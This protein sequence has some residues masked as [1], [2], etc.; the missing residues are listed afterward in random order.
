[1]TINTL[2]QRHILFLLHKIFTTMCRHH[3]L[4]AHCTQASHFE[5]AESGQSCVSFAVLTVDGS[6]LSTPNREWM[7]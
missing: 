3:S 2:K 6:V 7:Q 4:P 1:M 5:K